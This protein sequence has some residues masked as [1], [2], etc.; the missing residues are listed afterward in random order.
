MPVKKVPGGYIIVPRRVGPQQPKRK[1]ERTTD[2][3][4][5]LMEG[6]GGGEVMQQ[7]VIEGGV[8]DTYSESVD[9]ATV[10]AGAPKP[11][12][13]GSQVAKAKVSSGYA[14]KPGKATRTARS[15]PSRPPSRPGGG[16]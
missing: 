3:E 5:M 4:E 8:H 9:P 6:G 12:D 15:R 10:E 13:H 14:A 16:R 1:Q 7:A 11:V 2:E